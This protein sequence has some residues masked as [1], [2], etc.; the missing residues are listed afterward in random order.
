MAFTS[1]NEETLCLIVNFEHTPEKLHLKR[2][3]RKLSILLG[4]FKG[5]KTWIGSLLSL[6]ILSHFLKLCKM[7]A[8]GS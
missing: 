3:E 2:N 6:N 8:Y 7:F 1:K 5:K 4:S